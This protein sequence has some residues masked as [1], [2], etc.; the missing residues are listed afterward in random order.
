MT[1]KAEQQKKGNNYF[2]QT[3]E[4]KSKKSRPYDYKDGIKIRWNEFIFSRLIL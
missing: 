3:N 4:L 1:V 2:S